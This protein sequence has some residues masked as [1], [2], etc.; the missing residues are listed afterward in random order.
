MKK[1]I[2]YFATTLIILGLLS[3]ALL[4][5]FNPSFIGLWVA[6]F[7]GGIL[8]ICIGSLVLIANVKTKTRL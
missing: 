1:I 4:A 2:N 5:I 6:W 3:L 7:A 8:M